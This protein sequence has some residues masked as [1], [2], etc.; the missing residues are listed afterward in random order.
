MTNDEIKSLA[1]ERLQGVEGILGIGITRGAEKEIPYIMCLN[2]KT[3]VEVD[4]RLFDIDHKAVATGKIKP[5]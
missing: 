5:L 3:K 4:E 2:K 1:K